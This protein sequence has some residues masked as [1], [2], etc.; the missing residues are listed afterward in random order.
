MENENRDR[1]LKMMAVQNG[2]DE[3]QRVPVQKLHDVLESIND[4][5]IALDHELLITY[6]NRVAER[7]L[8]KRREDVLQH[9]VFEVFPE[10]TGSV[11]EEK[12]SEALQINQN[13]AFATYFDKPPYQNWYDMRIQVQEN[14]L[15]I[16]FQVITGR[17]RIEEILRQ[18]DDRYKLLFN[19]MLNAFAV[20]EIICDDQD[21]PV[22]YRFLEV[23]P[24]FE[25]QIG[26]PA[27]RITGKT[28]LEILPNTEKFWI[29]TYGKV[30][31]TGEPVNFE[32]YSQAI[33]K[34]YHVVAFSPKIKQF[35]TI[36][37]DITRRKIAEE[38][39]LKA[40]DDLDV[41]VQERTLELL[42]INQKLHSEIIERK[43]AEQISQLERAKLK[44]ILDTM[45]GGVYII[46]QDYDIEYIN[47]Y[48]EAEFGKIKGQKCY[49]YYHDRC[50]P[51]PWCV[52]E[53][54]F[55]GESLKWEWHFNKV[56]KTY[57]LFDT[58]LQN[59]DGT[60]SK[61]EIFYD[62]TARKA[63]ENEIN[64]RN[65]ELAAINEIGR[66]ITSTLDLHRVLAELLNHIKGVIGAQLCTV[67]LVDAETQD[68]LFYQLSEG[69]DKVELTW[70]QRLKQG[71]GVS[72]WVIEHK[73]SVVLDDVIR[74]PRPKL[75]YYDQIDFHPRS[76]ASIPM[77]ARDTVIGTIGLFHEEAGM[78]D[79]GDVSLVEAVAAQAA[80][81][82]QNAKLYEAERQARRTAETMRSTVLDLSQTLETET[83]LET[84]LDQLQKVVP[85]DSAH[86]YLID[87]QRYAMR[88]GCPRGRAVG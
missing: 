60:I 42:E 53:R 59:A 46:N 73:Q 29:E 9:Y 17:I 7:T 76:M 88:A 25:K 21:K 40:N 82:I 48:M 64:R 23:N 3:N 49:A 12:F 66:A 1:N 43:L 50:E 69:A 8:E 5:Y 85:F 84:L 22:D 77:I 33:G 4:A 81:I 79:A 63:A 47:P 57:E 16:Y 39:L 2:Q 86:A 55:K 11:F 45:P 54:V 38:E 67:G 74:D 26:L 37:E 6:F 71:E 62:I 80:V 19:R 32:H 34:Y 78:F 35:A 18:S 72:G 30:A 68:L 58:P 52:N 24:A 44:G 13:I 41:R 56:D 31:L 70:E 83:I 61:L 10:F 65:R 75:G 20:H 51:C 36:F 27:D 15:A 28:V 87:D 14:G